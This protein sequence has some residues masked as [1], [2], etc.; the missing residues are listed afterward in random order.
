[1]LPLFIDIGWLG[2]PIDVAT[3]VLV[4]VILKSRLS[5]M[6]AGVVALAREHQGV[7]D[8]QLQEELDVDDDT[9]E[10]IRTTIVCGGEARDE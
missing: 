7:D 3:F 1:V 9:V 6:A 4:A 8:D 5:T 10:S 2:S